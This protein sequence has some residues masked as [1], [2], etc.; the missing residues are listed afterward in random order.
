MK[1]GVII[2]ARMGSTRLPGKVLKKIK[3]K[4]VLAHVIE[5]TLQSKE[6]DEVIIATTVN[7]RDD[8]IVEE[9]ILNGVVVF[10]GSEDDVLERY[11]GAATASSLDIIVRV[12]SDCPLIDPFVIDDLVKVYMKGRYNIATN[13]SADLSKRTYPR[14]LDVEVFSMK[15]LKL[16]YVN[17]EEKY[18]REHVTPYIYQ[19]SESTFHHLNNQDYSK[20]RL[21]LDTVEDFELISEIYNLLYTGKHDFYFEEIISCLKKNR[22]LTNINN[23]IEQKKIK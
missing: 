23:H 19:R 9:A 1:I 20:Y 15:E 8:A 2:Q 22:T 21:T 5:R 7:R 18:Q 16:A 3:G 4:T 17:A 12:T 11:Y 10:R 14:G 6:V 13:A